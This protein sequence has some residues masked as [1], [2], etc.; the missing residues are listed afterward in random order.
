MC[1]LSGSGRGENDTL[2]IGDTVEG[3]VTAVRECKITSWLLGIFQRGTIGSFTALCREV[4]QRR[5][6]AILEGDVKVVLVNF[7]YVL[8]VL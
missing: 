4:A 6:D 3:V 1:P 5:W 7:G 2:M 8:G